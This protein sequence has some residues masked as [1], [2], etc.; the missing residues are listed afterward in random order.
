MRKYVQSSIAFLG[1]RGID[2][3]VDKAAADCHQSGVW[4][5]ERAA[6]AGAEAGAVAIALAIS[7][8]YST[9]TRRDAKRPRANVNR[10]SP[11]PQQH[12]PLN[13]LMH[14]IPV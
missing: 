4:F 5:V 11:A 1:L 9:P 13:L 7:P 2:E 14:A 10:Q 12:L 6:G 3:A 8:S